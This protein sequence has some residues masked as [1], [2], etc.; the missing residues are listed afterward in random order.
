MNLKRVKSV[1]ISIFSVLFGVFSIQAQQQEGLSKSSS[2]KSTVFGIKSGASLYYGNLGLN[3]AVFI[4]T[5]FCDKITLQ[6]ELNYIQHNLRVHNALLVSDIVED[7][8][9]LV[10]RYRS[11]YILMP[12][13]FKSSHSNWYS[14]LGFY[15]G[16]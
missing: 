15:T 1:L 8:D 4:N 11:D 14:L 5:K 13:Y 7:Q 6:L 3:S 16:V 9:L 10:D 12:F 2:L